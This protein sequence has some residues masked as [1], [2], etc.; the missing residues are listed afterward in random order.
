MSGGPTLKMEFPHLRFSTLTT[1][2][3]N[4]LNENDRSSTVELVDY[5]L[6]TGHFLR[7]LAECWRRMQSARDNHALACNF[8]KYSPILK[9]F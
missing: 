8:A 9:F 6:A 5:T 3:A 2:A 7:H 1:E 4:R